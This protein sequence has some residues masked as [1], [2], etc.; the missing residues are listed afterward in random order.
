M[1][2]D[3]YRPA[4]EVFIDAVGD[5]EHRA[6]FGRA[7]KRFKDTGLGLSIEV[8][9]YLVQQQHGRVCRCGAGDGQKLPLALREHPVSTHRIIAAR[10]GLDGGIQTGKLRGIP[11]H[12]FGDAGVAQRDLFQHRTRHTGK[13][14]LHTADAG[15][16]L[17][18]RDVRHVHAAD[19]HRPGFRVI[20]SQQQLEDGALSGTRPARQR[21][22]LALLDG[23]GKIVQDVLFAV[24]EGHMRNHHIT[25]GRGLP[26]LGDGAFRLVKEG[27][28]ALHARHRRLDGLY[29]HAKAL[30]GRKDAGN[31]VDDGHRGADRH[32]EQRQDSRIAGSREEHDDADHGGI[33]H[34]HDGRIDRV[35][36]IRPLHRGIAFADAPVIAALHVVF[37]TQSPDGADIVQ[38]FRYLAGHS[39][40]RPAVIQLRCQHPRLHMAGERGEQRQHQQQNQ[41]KAGILHG[42]DRHDGE[43]AAGDAPLGIYVMMPSSIPATPFETNGADFTAEDMKQWKDHPLVLGLGEVMCYPAVLSKEEQIMKKLELCK[44]M[45]IDGHAPG[46]SGE[47]LKAYVE[48]GVMTDHECTSFEE[49]KEKCLAGMKILVREGSAARNVENIVPGLVKEPEFIAHFMF[50]TDDKHLDTIENEGHISYNIKKSIQLGMNPISAVKMATYNAAKTYGLNDIGVLEE[51]KDADIVILDS[52]ESVEVHS[53]YKQGRIVNTEFFTKEAKPVNESMLHTV[54]LKNISKDKIQVKAEGKITVIGMIPGQIVTK[55][56]QEEVPSKD[57]LFTP[58]SEYSKLCVF[59]RHRGTGN[60]AAAPIKGYGITNGAIATSVAHDSHNI[61]AA[62][63]NDEDIIKAIQTIEEIQGGYALVSEGRVLGTLPLTVAGLLSQKPAKDIQKGIDELLQKAW[64]LGISRDIDP[65]I[66]LSFMALPVIPSLRLTD[67]G[68][69]DVDTFQL[70]KS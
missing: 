63:D 66:T 7:A 12:L 46:L 30:D 8:G 40:D 22:L 10:Q 11:C 29:L 64:K 23:H 48:A 26:L 56:L 69:V 19:G 4:A 43:D 49:A 55:F 60:A 34:Q 51:G 20:K 1:R 25:P 57:G 47:D 44:G 53:V 45:V 35:I 32:P 21:H 31:V 28:D 42:D 33:Q 14:L 59:E 15:A 38:C 62:G 5:G 17:G 41:R 13:M 67:L 70:L 37:Q 39:G 9:R 3:L 24:T 16:A 36:K 2:P 58:D 54:V 50:C 68:L 27:V 61:I 65:F 52:L 18:V 6:P